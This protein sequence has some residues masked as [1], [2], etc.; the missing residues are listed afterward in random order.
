MQK[1]TVEQKDIDSKIYATKNRI[2]KTEQDLGKSLSELTK[3]KEIN[4]SDSL[5]SEITE[6]GKNLDNEISKIEEKIK[7][8]ESEKS[9]IQDN[10]QEQTKLRKS[11]HRLT[12]EVER[13]EKE[14][15]D[16][17]SRFVYSPNKSELDN[18]GKNGNK[19]QNYNSPQIPKYA[20][21]EVGTLFETTDTYYLETTDTYYLEIADYDDLEK[22]NDLK[23][24]YKDKTYKVVVGD[25]N[26]SNY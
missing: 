13:I 25:N 11:N 6:K 4:I 26:E 5:I 20:L 10:L 14:L 24:R 3:L 18:L 7:S 21:P 9:V 16:K 15:E 1:I 8:L 12:N 17:Y 23:N 19:S 2:S 22:A